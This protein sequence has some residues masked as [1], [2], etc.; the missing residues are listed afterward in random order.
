MELI[1]IRSIRVYLQRKVLYPNNNHT[2]QWSTTIVEGFTLTNIRKL[3][4]KHYTGYSMTVP[5]TPPSTLSIWTSPII[6]YQLAIKIYTSG[7][8]KNAKA[9]VPLYIL[10]EAVESLTLIPSYDEVIASDL[11]SYEDALKIK[12]VET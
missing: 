10:K 9:K 2:T 5:D 6:C 11:P 3:Q 7:F 1:P 12:E 8:N 4:E